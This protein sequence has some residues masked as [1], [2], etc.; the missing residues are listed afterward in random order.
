MTLSDLSALL[1]LIV[2]A[3]GMILILLAIAFWRNHVFTA[4]LTLVIFVL[5]FLTVILRGNQGGTRVTP[6][7]VMDHYAIVVIGLLVAASFFITLFAFSYLG[8]RVEKPEEF[9]LLLVSG[10]LGSCVLASSA[11][12]ASFFLGLEILSISLYAMIAYTYRNPLSIEAGVKYLVLAASS[13][14]VLL[15]GMALVYAQIGSMDFSDIAIALTTSNPPMNSVIVLSGFIMMLVGIGFKLAL[16]PFHLWTPDVYEGAPAPVTAFVATISKGGMYALLLRFFDQID[17]NAQTTLFL[18]FMVIAIATMFAG[19]LLALLQTNL[20][21]LLA[22][23]SIA[24]LGYLLIPFLADGADATSAALFFLASY[25]I[26]ILVAFGVVALMSPANQDASHLDEYKGLMWRK[27]WLAAA[28]TGAMF[29]LAGIPLTV[30]FMG[31]FYLVMAGVRSTL[32]LLVIILVVTSAISFYYYLRVVVILFSNQTR[33][34]SQT[35][36]EQT[37]Q[38]APIGGVALAGLT[39]MLVGFGI[40]PSPLLRIIQTLAAFIH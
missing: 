35:E 12:F 23:S 32:W 15:F 2:M 16:V 19:N 17:L 10:T 34:S 37:S 38:F 30:G 5:T 29:S 4:G 33:I 11:H 1:P 21:R 27:P 36:P 26:A 9:Y 8:K 6:L 3:T 20:K 24:N 31:K 25:F 13:A 39:V 14:A 28:L 40:F 7:L 18:V 22:Y